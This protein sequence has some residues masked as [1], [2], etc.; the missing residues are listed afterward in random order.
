MPEPQSRLKEGPSFLSHC[1]ST[2]GYS[3]VMYSYVVYFQCVSISV[4]TVMGM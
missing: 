1:T 2:A 3:P 4:A